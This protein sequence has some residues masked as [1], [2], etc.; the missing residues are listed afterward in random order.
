RERARYIFRKGKGRGGAQPPNNWESVFGGPA[1]TRVPDP[2]GT[3]PS[4]E[5]YLHLFD[6]SQPDLDWRNPQVP[7]MFQAV[8]TFCLD[9]AADVAHVLNRIGSLRNR[10]GLAPGQGALRG[11]REDRSMVERS[12]RDEPMWDQPEIHD[13]YRSWRRILEEYAGDRMAVAEA[14]TQ[15]PES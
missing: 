12:V 7:P 11:D 10:G 5:W 8:L 4:T 15:S 9:L 2:A 3:G 14:W 6:A 13:V 1:W